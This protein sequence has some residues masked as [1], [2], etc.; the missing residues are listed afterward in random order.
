MGEE[1][2][3]RPYGIGITELMEKL[4]QQKM[5]DDNDK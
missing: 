2:T 1:G 3:P 5:F 4:G